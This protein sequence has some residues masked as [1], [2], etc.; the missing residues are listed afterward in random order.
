MRL[1]QWLGLGIFLLGSGVG[2]LLTKI[3]LVG[4]HG[5]NHQV[6]TPVQPSHNSTLN[7]KS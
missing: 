1:D 2:A 3:A 6:G 7:Q 4:L 5:A